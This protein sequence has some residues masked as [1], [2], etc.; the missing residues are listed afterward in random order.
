MLI[1]GKFYLPHRE[2]TKRQGTVAHRNILRDRQPSTAAPASLKCDG[3]KGTEI[4]YGERQ[5]IL[6]WAD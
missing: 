3:S 5:N 6:Y 1:Y 2:K 4:V